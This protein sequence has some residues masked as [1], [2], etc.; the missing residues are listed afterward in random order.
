MSKKELGTKSQG[1]LFLQRMAHGWD[2][3]YHDLPPL[4]SDPRTSESD[5]TISQHIENFI[6]HNDFSG[7]A[8]SHEAPVPNSNF[9]ANYRSNPTIA[10][11]SS[12]CAY[13][14]YC[15]ETQWQ[16]DG[17]Q[18]E[19]DY[20]QSCGNSDIT[21]F[22]IDGLTGS[23]SFP[24]TF[25][26]DLQGIKQDCGMLGTSFL[27][28]YS[29]I[30]SC[31]DADAS[32]IRPSCKFMASQLFPKPKTDVPTK[33][34]SSEWFFN[35]TGSMTI[36]TE[37]LCPNLS[38]SNAISPSNVKSGESIVECVQE[39]MESQEKSIES[40][41]VQDESS[42][43]SYTVTTSENET[44]HNRKDD[45][46]Q[47]HKQK[48]N[49]ER[50]L[51]E[52]KYSDI[53]I[54]NDENLTGDKDPNGPNEEEPIPSGAP[55]IITTSSK[56]KDNLDEKKE[57][58][59]FSVEQ[60]SS[61][62]NST[63]GQDENMETDCQ[64]K[65]IPTNLSQS[66]DPPAKKASSSK[67]T[68]NE[69]GECTSTLMSSSHDSES[70]LQLLEHQ[71][72]SVAQDNVCRSHAE[73]S[74]SH[75]SNAGVACLSESC[76]QPKSLSKEMSVCPDKESTSAA[77]QTPTVCHPDP[78][79]SGPGDTCDSIDTN[80]KNKQGVARDI[81]SHLKSDS[82]DMNSHFDKELTN[83]AKETSETLTPDK[84][85][86]GPTVT[87]DSLSVDT[88]DKNAQDAA[89]HSESS[90]HPDSS[91]TD[92]SP[93][94][95]KEQRTSTTSSTDPQCSSHAVNSDG[96]KLEVSSSSESS[97][98]TSASETDINSCSEKRWTIPV[99]QEPLSPGED[100]AENARGSFEELDSAEEHSMS[101]MLY[102][103]P[104]SRED[105]SCD[106][107]ETKLIS[108]PFKETTLARAGADSEGQGS[109]FKSSVEMRKMLQPVVTLKN[110]E[111]TNG[112]NHSYHCAVCQH[113]THN[114]DH[115]I[116]HYHCCH[117]EH[118]FQFCKTCNVY[119]MKNEQAEKH[120]C[121]LTKKRPRSSSNSALKKP[122]NH[123][124]RHRCIKCKLAF[125]KIIHYVKHMRTHTGK[126]P[127]RCDACGIYFA[128]RSTMNRHKSVPGRCKPSKRPVTNS[129]ADII[130]T[131]TPSL[132]EEVQGDSSANMPKCYVKLFD[133][134]KTDTWDVCVKSSVK[135]AKK[136]YSNIHHGKS[137]AIASDA[138]SVSSVKDEKMEKEIRGKHKCPLCPRLFKYSYNRS[139]HLRFCVKEAI[140]G[141]KK[142][143]GGK[144][145]CP[146]CYATFTLSSNR[147]RHI[148]VTCLRDYI[149]RLSKDVAQSRQTADQQKTKEHEQKTLSKEHVQKTP[150]K[151]PVEKTLSKEPVQQTQS[152]E[153]EQKKPLKTFKVLPRY[154]CNLCPAVF[155]HA[156]GKYRHMKKHELF[157]LTGKMFK[158]RNSILS[159]M[160]AQENSSNAKTE[161]S[162]DDLKA[163]EENS[164]PALSC[165]FCGKC[166]SDAQTLKKH[167]RGHRGA[168]PYRC[169]EC[170]RGF[171]KH[172]HL[173]GHKI[174]HQRRIQCT[175]CKKILPNI[176]ELIQHRST[177]LKRGMLKCPDC[178]M[179]FPHPAHLLRHVKTHKN[180]E[181]QAPPQL[182]NKEP[183]KPQ[184]SLESVEKE[185]RTEHLQCS[186]CKE[187]FIDSHLLRRH[188][189][190][191]ISGPSSSQCPFCKRNLSSRRSLLRHM[192]RHTRGKPFLCTNCGK[193][194]TQDTSLKLHSEKCL[195]R[196]TQT[197]VA[198]ESNNKT[199]NPYHC[200]YCPRTFCKKDRLKNHHRGHMAK[201]LHFCSTCGQYFG[202]NAIAR[203]RND[204]ENTDKSDA[205]LPPAKKDD[206]NSTLQTRKMVHR[207]PLKC[208]AANMFKLQCPECP[209]RFRFPS[210]LSR[211]LVSHTGVQPYACMHCGDRF[212]SHSMRVQ[213]EAVC[214]DAQ[215]E[216]P[217]NVSSDT[218]TKQE[219][220]PTRRETA[221]KPK[222][223][224][225]EFKCKFCTKSFMKLR[226]LRAHILTH[227]E[228]KPYRCKACDSCFSRYDHLKV[229][230]TRCRGKKTRLEVRIPKIS[231]DDVGKGWQN[232]FSREPAQKQETF[233]CEVCSRSFSA[234]SKLSR[235]FSMFHA[236]KLFKCTRCGSSFA[237][238]R[239][240]KKHKKRYK[241]RKP[242]DETNASQLPTTDPPA[243]NV[244]KPLDVIKN[245]I[246]QRVQPYFHK[247]LKYSCSYCPRAF[248]NSWQLNVHV[249]LHTGEKPY[250]CDYCGMKFIRKDYV[251]RH[252]PKCLKKSRRNT[253]LCDRCGGFFSQEKLE[254]HKKSCTSTPSS[255]VSTESKRSTSDST[256]KGFS[257]AYC[258]SRFLLFSQL[259]EHFLNAHKVETMAPP[260]STA[261]LQQLL[262]NIPNIKE[263]PSDK[264]CDEERSGGANVICNL[265]AALQSEA[266]KT[267]F[268]QDCNM[269][270]LNKA[271]LAGHLRTHAVGRPH[272]CKL[273][274]RGFWNKTLLRNHYR[275]CRNG[276][277]TNQESEGPLTGE[278]DFALNESVLVF[279]EGSKTT[280]TGVLQ[281]NFSC[282]DEAVD[283]Y[284][285]NSEEN[286]EQSSSSKEKKTVQYQCSECDKSF[287]DGLMLISHL[288]DHGRE[289]Q[290][291]KRN[292]C[293]KCGRVCSS[294]ANLEKHMRMHGSG[295]AFP[296][297]SCSA[298]FDTISEL[299]SH[300]SCHDPSRPYVCRLC[301]LRFSTRPSLCSHYRDEH[302]DDVFSCK[303]C[304]KS[305]AIKKSLSRHYKRWHHKEQRDAAQEKSSSE[306]HS[307]SQAGESDEDENNGSEDSDSDSAPYFPCHVCGKT[308][309]TSENLEDH[310]LCHVGVKP[311][312]CSECG[313]CFVQASQLQQHQRMHNSEFQCQMCGR[314]FVSLFALRKHK[315]SH[316]RNRPY[317]CPKC[318]LSFTGPTQLAEHMS[319][320]REENFPCDIC[321]RVF[322]SKS[323][324]AE[325]RKSHSSSGPPP[326]LSRG[327]HEKSVATSESSFV[328]TSEL[329]YRCGVCN[330]RFR[331]PEELSE[332]GCMEAKER[333]YSCTDCNQHFLHAS[334]LKK[335]RNT[336]QPSWSN[337]EY[338][339]NLCN[340][341]F[342]SSQ[343]F[344]S[345]V[346]SHGGTAAGDGGSSHSFICPVCHLCFSS[347]TELIVHFPTH[348]D[349]AL[350]HDKIASPSGSELKEQHHLI[351]PSEYE[352][353]QCGLC[354]FGAEAYRQHHCPRRQQA[355]IETKY[356]NPSAKTS[357]SAYYRATGEEEEVDVTGEDFFYCPICSMQFSS[358]SGL[359]EHQNEEHLNGKPFSCD[360]CGK[361]F[362]KKRYLYKHQRRH[363]EKAAH[364]AQVAENTIKCPQCVLR[365]STA[366]ELSLHMR[367][368][369]EKQ[370]GEYRCDMCY[371][372]FSQWSFLKQ[373]QE[374]HVGEVVYECTECDKA[375]AFPHLLEEHQQTHA[376]SSQ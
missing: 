92:I 341:S 124:G 227:N 372:S 316:G 181:N 225:E 271:G 47:D 260:V 229:H 49:V 287:T 221:Q 133:I 42:T 357:S 95:E 200:S 237:H 50:D 307:S 234:K 197:H 135:R 351:P 77:R 244:P 250:S 152:K 299:E 68:T 118:N 158:Y 191:H 132:K 364:A 76:L 199:K 53:S 183:L 371:K 187:V 255:S 101:G 80:D 51:T 219:S 334:H 354:F 130:T 324:R 315:H 74:D 85:G 38:E 323:S 81:E 268:C 70:S 105:S 173:L 116:E 366:L 285:Q 274:N 289:E 216:E 59:S 7:I 163:P 204:C 121:T 313:K 24:S 344:L 136:H 4:S 258:G 97:L 192:V 18:M 164:A 328:F 293:S 251:K 34:S 193:R 109:Q 327:E 333:P 148:K 275:K 206:N 202:I 131:E 72:E 17:E 247:T 165:H 369:A 211:H 303:F 214:D 353:T 160:S 280:G 169:L 13:Q 346:R 188:S 300:K 156:S 122:R 170:K 9:T 243:E 175:V 180:T 331:D 277:F 71:S 288:E 213:H 205:N 31:S 113:T 207:K 44:V 201:S 16:A 269:S 56:E 82:T 198:V 291:K 232:R 246:I 25:A 262:A 321:N 162:M 267:F 159:I 330:V 143:V 14:R 75:V 272:N 265:G 37:S 73:M 46:C 342:S 190:T 182:E 114:M 185:E 103:E 189:L 115:L 102:G 137:V 335:H 212:A 295:P 138:T 228:V 217:P 48:E 329:K 166:F 167:E 355:I 89:I 154:K 223:D 30:S 19:K 249:R 370:V 157:K 336:H 127:F 226:S 375:F 10:N 363:N 365:F 87:G 153:N 222:A 54:S 69:L 123:H 195:P 147:Y 362:A 26:A 304:S 145:Q 20:L 146:L 2:T 177:H 349:G 348:P 263:E 66:S 36:P 128:Q 273:C 155:R 45:S 297:P 179:Q 184:Q 168:R 279:K 253:V 209:Q 39:K 306:Q 151:E 286:Q 203:H 6:G 11:S 55:N 350:E 305:Y 343:H 126:T 235:H 284:L 35:Q 309:S 91:N 104:L 376:G 28:N 311:H 318:N 373:H 230:Q 61:I 266:P 107:D 345:H 194:F 320:H 220:M 310:Q 368:H 374:S 356:L 5:G 308:F 352:C 196:Q 129:D 254:N 347:A 294:Q 93:C 41:A 325:H 290:Q 27:E 90:L 208:N 240:L 161:E 96:T 144:Y 218:E 319:A 276:G 94:L 282:K 98:Q 32:E 322:Q 245:R 40:C 86:S 12:D 332:H 1:F 264:S 241:C 361:T 67:D 337:S 65:E 52:G 22:A 112:M 149:N 119:L 186:L 210:L 231:L 174:V 252:Y 239:S 141:G 60:D 270:F 326:S 3:Y 171:K 312:E 367:V 359:L 278:I 358:K 21:D 8:T 139:R 172:A 62:S 242:S 301:H 100:I 111:S 178:P 238:E 99:S 257:C 314:G 140:Y 298:K 302:E 281:T 29:D 296:C 224:D 108:S 58:E 125:S 117:S 63:S 106:T 79:C 283:E 176:G 233:E 110:L 150:S 64:D 84:D 339:C 120:L 338:P 256:P 259:Q 236:P 83:A 78:D 340:S 33:H 261:P 142:K 360:I 134:S 57:Q 15:S 43:T 317:R 292:T 88:S 23:E 248:A 215:K